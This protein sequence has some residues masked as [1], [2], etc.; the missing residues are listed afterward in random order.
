MM[1][2][3]GETDRRNA[4]MKNFPIFYPAHPKILLIF[5]FFL[6]YAR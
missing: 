1:D 6:R 4:A 5:L 2:K 3:M